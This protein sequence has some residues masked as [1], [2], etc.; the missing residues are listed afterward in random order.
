MVGMKPTLRL[1]L[2][3]EMAATRVMFLQGRKAQMLLWG[4]SAKRHAP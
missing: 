3:S 1:A 2:L 4:A